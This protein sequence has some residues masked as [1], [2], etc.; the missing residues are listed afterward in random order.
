MTNFFV[1]NNTKEFPSSNWSG[2]SGDQNRGALYT[3]C[4]TTIKTS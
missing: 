3:P 4:G 2:R 1:Y